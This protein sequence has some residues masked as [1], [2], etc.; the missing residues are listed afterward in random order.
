MPATRGSIVVA[1]R[2][3]FAKALKQISVMW[4]RFWPA[5]STT[6]RLHCAPR[7]KAS[8]KTSASSVS[9]VPSLAFPD[10]EGA[11]AEIDGGGGAGLVH[12]KRRPP[13]AGDAGAIAECC[14]DC[15]TQDDADVLGGVMTVDLDVA[16]RGHREIEQAVARDLVEHVVE[17]RER[18]RD[19]ALAGPVE[20]D[21]DLDARLLRRA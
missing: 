3:A 17:E 1:A 2:K 20:G 15:F 12:R 18:R 6:W 10:H 9:Q 21:L 8:K 19:A 14:S 5:W 4:C 11:A 16:L 7:A 13:V